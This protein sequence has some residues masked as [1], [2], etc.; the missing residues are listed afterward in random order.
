MV[1]VQGDVGQ[2]VVAEICEELASKGEHL[3][4]EIEE[5]RSL[6]GSCVKA[7]ERLHL[8]QS[9]WSEKL[10]GIKAR[11][12]Q[13]EKKKDE[14]ALMLDLHQVLRSSGGLEEAVRSVILC[15]LSWLLHVCLVL[16]VPHFAYLTSAALVSTRVA[17]QAVSA[18]VKDELEVRW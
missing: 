4:K 3:N 10:R 12:S 14:T 5:M 11:M 18:E 16:S 2:S 15:L 9:A 6:E 7:L 13:I 17:Q 8:E 1:M